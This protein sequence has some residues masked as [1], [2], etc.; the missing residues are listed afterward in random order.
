M[1]PIKLTMQAF[2]SY[3]EKTTIDFTVPN[4]NLFLVTGDTGAGKTTIFDA[5]VFAL[6]GEASSVN[7]R[8]DGVELQSQF[9]DYGTRPFVEL[10]FA[11]MA[12]GE[13]RIY[14]VNRSPQH[15]RPKAR[16]TGE[17]HETEKVSLTMADGSEYAG[18][19][20]E[21]DQKLEE[22]IGLTK[23]QFMQ[24]AMIAQGE[25]ME[26]LRAKSDDKKVIFR[27]LFHT[28]L[29][30]KIVEELGERRREKTSQ[31]AQIKTACQQEV[32]HVVLPPEH[33]LLELKE[34]I[35]NAQR[36]NTSD[37]EQMVAGLLDLCETM[38]IWQQEAE[39]VRAVASADRDKKRDAYTKAE[40]LN[41]AFSQLERANRELAEC[42]EQEVSIE[43]T[44]ALIKDI[45]VAYDLSG[46]H[47]K[48]TE[49]S[50]TYAEATAKLA[51]QKEQLPELC[52]AYEQ[53]ITEE[54]AAKEAHDA[55]LEVFSKVTERVEKALAAFAAIKS[56]KAD[57]GKK[58]AA[59]V[60]AE[61]KEQQAKSKLDGFLTDVKAAIDHL[62]PVVKQQAKAEAA[63]VAYEKAKA[64][65]NHKKEE[66]D[67][68]S[69]AFLDAQAGLI[70]KTLVAGEPCPVCG[71]IEHPAPARLVEE[72]AHLTREMID[73]LAALVSK[74]DQDRTDAST[75]A[76]E[77]A[78]LLEEIRK[79]M[80]EQCQAELREAYD[81]AVAE[82][83]EAKTAYATSQETL[84]GLTTS[85]DYEDEM[86]AKTALLSA[87]KEKEAK[88]AIYNAAHQASLKAKASKETA[89]TLIAEYESNLP[90]LEAK[91]QAA[92]TGYEIMLKT[93]AFISTLASDEKEE[94]WKLLTERYK[95]SDI[96]TLQTQVTTYQNKKAVAEGTK[97]TALEAI[98]G[99]ERPDM[100]VLGQ[101]KLQ[102]EEALSQAQKVLDQIREDYRTNKNVYE[103]LAPKMEERSQ[104]M[105]KHTRIDSLYNRLAG[106]VTGARMDIETFVL[107]YYLQRILYA[108]NARFSDMSAGQFELRMVGEEQAGAGKNRGLDLMVYSTITGKEREVRTLS[109]GESFMAAL[110]LALGMA[111]MIQENSSSI[112]LDV[113]FIDEGFGSLDDHSREQAVKVLQR[114]AS[115]DKLIGIIS[116]VTEL[117]QKIDDQL[118]VRKD[119]KGSHAKWEVS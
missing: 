108:A 33:S 97:N 112:H 57:C 39:E 55:Q 62:A 6:Y 77:A 37:M 86:A 28:E 16:G 14:T 93:V 44:I 30:Q 117:K 78:T 65:Y 95:K 83:H 17:T 24:V 88:V 5:I 8:K 2:G 110:S 34:R 82:S 10:S 104:V 69:S 20:K 79:T 1:K 66:Y 107:R 50:K 63:V 113:M 111:D 3:G 32:S 49:A 25:F 64:E 22:I 51:E 91:Q 67:A 53:A 29:Y 98:G 92:K 23:S 48:Y 47:E 74:L 103:A 72:Q 4:Q 99:Q 42:K 35:C 56:A 41:T 31:M 81:E 100:E 60:L 70:A 85:Q 11:E 75:A 101:E 52:A 106:N 114:M 68:K 87:T 9:V 26:L 27:K 18:N 61:K 115:G 73:E 96:D 45:N 36:L 43:D 118:V 80:A 58:E 90:Q 119:E 84:K 76:N 54:T 15:M 12:G 71:S 109:G 46:A 13:E 89:E 105:K 21:V 19:Q 94:S 7:N 38:D 40:G 102:A 59:K 116:H